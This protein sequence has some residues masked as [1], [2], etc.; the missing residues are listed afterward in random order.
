MLA[1][2]TPLIPMGLEAGE[3]VP[4]VEGLSGRGPREAM[5]IG[6]V[7]DMAVGMDMVIGKRAG[8]GN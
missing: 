5:G 7:R 3:V 6:A 2:R 4:E 8:I 1:E